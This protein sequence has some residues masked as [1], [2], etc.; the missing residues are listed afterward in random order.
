M[1]VLLKP[2]RNMKTDLKGFEESWSQASD[3]F[4]TTAPK[5]VHD[6]LSGIQY[7]HSCRSAAMASRNE[8]DEEV[9]SDR[10]HLDLNEPRDLDED[11]DCPDTTLSE[12]GLAE[13]IASQVPLREDLHAR[14][15]VEYARVAKI[16]GNDCTSWDLS[17]EEHVAVSATGDDLLKLAT[18]RTQLAEHVEKLNSLPEFVERAERAE[19]GADVI[20]IEDANVGGPHTESDGNGAQ[21]T[22]LVQAVPAG[23]A[24]TPV[25]PSQLNSEQRRAYDII[26]WHL[27][28]TLAGNEPPPL[29]MLVHGEG[30]TGKSKVIATTTQAFVERTVLHWLLKAAYTG[31]AASL[32]DGKTTHIIGGIG[33]N[34]GRLKIFAVSATLTSCSQENLVMKRRKSFSCFG[35]IAAISLLTRH[36]CLERSLLHCCQEISALAKATLR[37]I[38]LVVST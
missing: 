6:I 16:F 14:M 8:E 10:Q 38:H 1:L 18:W 35:N 2:W 33:V 31:I 4:V 24:L 9:I 28:E 5:S 15:A 25:H 32:V 22:P 27:E 11:V 26:V 19:D 13:L 36:Q 7:F 17:G 29:R 20:Q 3:G 12:E 23:S 30:G 37:L 21:V 34:P